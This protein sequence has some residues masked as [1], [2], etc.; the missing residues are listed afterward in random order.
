MVP[1]LLTLTFHLREFQRHSTLIIR[2]AF[3]Y[4]QLGQFSKNR[5]NH[6]FMDKVALIKCIV[7]QHQSFFLTH[8]SRKIFSFL[9][10]S[11]RERPGLLDKAE[12][13]GKNMSDFKIPILSRE[14]CHYVI[15][16]TKCSNLIFISEIGMTKPISSTKEKVNFYR[17]LPLITGGG[18]GQLQCTQMRTRGIVIKIRSKYP[19]CTQVY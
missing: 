11:S 8:I 16:Q 3:H 1:I 6:N 5:R 19:F 17:G 12:R 4:L 9:K 13:Y 14:P 18:G 2:K 7:M 15:S 10:S